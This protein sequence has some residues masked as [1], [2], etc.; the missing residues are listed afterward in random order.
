M[1]GRIASARRSGKKRQGRRKRRGAS[2][3]QAQATP[4]TK[5]TARAAGNL[6][7]NISGAHVSRNGH[8]A[9]NAEI[10]VKEPRDPQIKLAPEPSAPLPIPPDHLAGDGLN[11]EVQGA[12]SS[13]DVW[14]PGWDTGFR[15]PKPSLDAPTGNDAAEACARDSHQRISH[16]VGVTALGTLA[17][18]GRAHASG[19]RTGRV[20]SL[21]R[22]RPAA[23]AVLALLLLGFALT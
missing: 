6:A 13:E 19:E 18:F 11:G 14:D 7:E 17:S 1:S 10:A 3:R 22:Q 15:L 2:N 21:A 23:A 9:E 12:E 16:G 5:T 20:L 4:N 8:V